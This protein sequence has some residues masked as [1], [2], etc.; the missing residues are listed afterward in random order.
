MSNNECSKKGIF[1]HLIIREGKIMWSISELKREARAVLKQCYPTALAVTAITA[2]LSNSGKVSGAISEK[3]PTL[4]GKIGGLAIASDIDLFAVIAIVLAV[5]SSTVVL[6]TLMLLISAPIKVGESRY[7][8]EGTQYR[9]DMKNILHGFTCGKYKNILVSLMLKEIFLA[10]WTMLLVIPGIVKGYAY[11]MVPFIL[12]ENPNLSPRQV[13]D[14]SCRMTKG[15][16][17]RVFLT[18]L[19]FIGWY[20]L[21]ALCFGVGTLFVMPYERATFAQL[22]L[23][24]RSDALDSGRVSLSELEY[25]L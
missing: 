15:Y 13:I 12:A 24:L 8:L 25:G 10:L 1:C 21:G 11:S 3:L 18:Q 20:L 16:K 6:S 4:T 5:L 7:F 19:S 9:F 2:V 14:I 17:F 22:Y 23:A